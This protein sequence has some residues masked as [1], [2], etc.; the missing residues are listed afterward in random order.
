MKILGFLLSVVIGLLLFS[1]T[2]PPGALY[3]AAGAFA[4]DVGSIWSIIVNLPL[5]HPI[6]SIIISFLM[7]KGGPIVWF[8][9]WVIRAIRDG[10][11]DDTE[12][13]GTLWRLA[14]IV[15]GFWPNKSRKVILTYAPRHWHPVIL[16][17]HDPTFRLVAVPLSKVI[18]VQNML[19]GKRVVGPGDQPVPSEDRG[20]DTQ[21][22]DSPGPESERGL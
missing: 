13:A 19:S 14:A 21:K 20:E 17:G 2:H 3:A 8:L 15:N 6:A 7:V 9:L 1:I 10:S 12:A 4:F 16:E 5:D 18:D 11:F 22:A